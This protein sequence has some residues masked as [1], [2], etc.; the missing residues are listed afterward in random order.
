MMYPLV[1]QLISAIRS[2]LGVSEEAPGEV[3][4]VIQ[5]PVV[6]DW[7]MEPVIRDSFVKVGRIAMSDEGMVFHSDLDERGFILL[8]EDIDAV[9]DG[10]TRNI[11][12]L[13]IMDNVGFARLSM[14]GKALKLAISPHYHTVPLRSVLAVLD[15]RNRK[16]AVFMGK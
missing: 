9:L 4:T 5:G 13:E 15:G 12:L 7:K 10:D 11:R 8:N 1:W 6:P 16:G 14:S 2:L 3:G